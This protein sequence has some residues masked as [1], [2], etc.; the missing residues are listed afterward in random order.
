[1]GAKNIYERFIWFDDRVR[2]KKYPNA[3]SLSDK[4]EIST[5]TAQRDI[6]FMRD[7]L[8]CPLRYDVSRKGYHYENDTFSLP[9][10]YLSSTELS[11][12]LIARKMLNDISG[13]YIG[14]EISSIVDK[15]TNVLNKHMSPGNRI[16]EAVSFQLIEYSPAEEAVFKCV[17][18][19][20][21]KQ[22]CLSFS[23][24]S[25]ARG[26]KSSRTVDPYHLVNY[27]GTWHLI[28]HCHLKN[29]MRDFVLGRITDARVLDETVEMP[30]EFD[31]KDYFRSS[32]GIY[33]GGPIKYVTLRFSPLKSR[34]VRGQVWHKDQKVK[35]LK[36][37]S[38][39]LSFPVADF[40]EIKREI[41]KHG[42]MVEVIEPKSLRKLIKTEA[43]KITEIY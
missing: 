30:S 37:G 13:G 7:R 14:E 22:K 26:E 33:K 11:S 8:R 21:L 34:W 12:L 4:F 40:S 16:D 19:G 17:L 32:F 1:M 9:M 35:N 42:S 20:C 10:V 15:I 29:T 18:E 6:D 36:D 38:L 27:M 24:Y 41:L 3:T 2:S 23:Y 28:G 25:P 5:K 43:E 39:E 31:P